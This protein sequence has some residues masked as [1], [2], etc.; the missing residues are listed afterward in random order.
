MCS[1]DLSASRR[2]IGSFNAQGDV[3]ATS[4]TGGLIGRKR[5]EDCMCG[6]MDK[7]LD[8]DLG[9]YGYYG[10]PGA[11]CML[12]PGP[13]DGLLSTVA[14]EKANITCVEEQGC[15]EEAAAVQS[16][17]SIYSRHMIPLSHVSK[18]YS[19][20]ESKLQREEEAYSKAEFE[21]QKGAEKK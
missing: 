15:V 4:T 12:C 2:Q 19:D 21:L 13:G 8:F 7:K 1:S 18:L 11:S 10:A 20:Y 5:I 16:A 14:V 6:K 3:T 9:Y 17:N